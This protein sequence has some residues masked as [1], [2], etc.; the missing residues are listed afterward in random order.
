MIETLE[1]Q[2][3]INLIVTVIVAMF[4]SSGFWAFIEWKL[5]NRK[6]VDENRQHQTDLLKGLAHDRIVY[7]GLK[8]IRR[9]WISADEYENLSLYLYKPYLAMEGNG[10]AR[11]IMT[12]VDQLPIRP[13]SYVQL[14]QEEEIKYT[15]K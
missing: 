13:P 6:D 11:R 3:I 15:P 2:T 8:Y 9:G 10:S 12:E 14:H 7:L 5:R 1:H 4:A